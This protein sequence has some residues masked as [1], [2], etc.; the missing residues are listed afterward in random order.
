MSTT[1][2]PMVSVVTPVYN[3]EEYLAECIES[4]V[5][6]SYD[7]WEHV[8]LDNCSTD[9]TGDIA[10][11]YGE[12]EGR[13]KIYRNDTVLPMLENWNRAMRLINAQ[14]KYCKVVHGDDWLFP[15]CLKQMVELADTHQ[16]VGIVGSYRLEEDK[17]TLDSL[18]Y[19]ST[20]VNG[21]ELCRGRFL[22]AHGVFGS[23]TTLMLR[24]DLVRSRDKFYSE[25]NLH[26]DTEICFDLLRTVDFGFVHQ[27]LTFTRR[28]NETVTSSARKLNTQAMG[29]LIILHKFGRDFLTEEEYQRSVKSQLKYYYRF[30][31]RHVLELRKSKVLG[32]HRKA[33]MD[34]GHSFSFVKLATSV[35]VVYFNMCL[36]KMKL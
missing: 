13:I 3:G 20:V 19:P 12:K 16:N 10:R 18:P 27:V 25:D 33:L 26:S 30:L 28:H 24:S 8:I 9:G 2:Q 31:G 11:S 29:R 14:S 21:R 34:G 32:H 23:P 22:G 35:F 5:A 4:V 15:E 17:I 1:G 36:N 6:Q 7:N